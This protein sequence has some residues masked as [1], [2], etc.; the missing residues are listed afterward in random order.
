MA[1]ETV[2]VTLE[3]DND[4]DEMTVPKGLIDILKESPDETATDVVGDIAMMGF[5]QRIHGAVHHAEGEPDEEIRALND[6]TMD[7]FEERF[8]A[9]FD[10]LTG[11]SH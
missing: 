8:G 2:T 11:H 4:T 1:S 7:L 6:A 9:T 3:S 10:E 5:A